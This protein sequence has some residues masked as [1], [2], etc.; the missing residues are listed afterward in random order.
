MSLL[1]PCVFSALS[2][3]NRVA[4]ALSAQEEV[5]EAVSATDGIDDT[6]WWGAGLVISPPLDVHPV[7][8]G[9]APLM[10]S[11]H[12]RDWRTVA[13]QVHA[14]GGRFMASLSHGST[15]AGLRQAVRACTP[16]DIA[17]LTEMIAAS[18]ALAHSA[19]FDG[20]E[21][22]AGHG[23]LLDGFLRSGS[24]PREDAYGGPVGHRVRLLLDVCEAAASVWSVERIGVRLTPWSGPR[25]MRDDDTLATFS[26][27]AAALDQLGVGYLHLVEPYP[28]RRSVL[29]GLRRDFGGAILASGAATIEEAETAI[30][31]GLADC[32]AFPRMPGVLTPG[33]GGFHAS[34][35]SRAAGTSCS[36]I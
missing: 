23:S 16:Q 14:G 4:V 15:A 19:G 5:R 36:L 30:A 27:V 33:E 35:A 10:T 9:A 28:R 34:L 7:G 22:H 1:D 31:S 17:A 8:P 29:A 11:R 24:N 20:I 13:D 2:L 25:A 26:Y 32:V 6:A 18:A 12:A 3:T 21:L